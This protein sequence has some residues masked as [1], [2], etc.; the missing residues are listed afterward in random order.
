MLTD[1]ALMLAIFIVMILMIIFVPVLG[2][3]IQLFLILPFLLYSSKH[4]V[5]YSI[6]L[7]IC[8]M[9]L[10]FIL[11]SFAGLFF[12]FL[13]GT[14]GLM[15]GYCIK[16]KESKQTIYIAS[17]IVFLISLVIVFVISALFF[18]LNFLTE[19]QQIF[20]TA[21]D[22]YI[23]TL[24]RLGQSPPLELQ[25]QLREM[26]R[27]LGLMAPTL[28]AGSA[29]LNVIVIIAVNFPI[30]K[31]LGVDVPKFSPFRNLSFP[32]SIVWI[33]LVVILLS[34]IVNN[35]S[36]PFWQMVILNASFILQ[37]LLVIQGLSFIFYFAHLKKWPRAIP[38]IAVVLTPFLPFFLSIVRVLGI[39]DIGFNL[40]QRL[41]QS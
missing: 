1:G 29:F 17:S 4:S 31:R 34:F 24:Q 26:I 8:A 36:G 28:M 14:T 33:Y 6:I 23:E 27:I 38:I 16:R 37:S 11:G 22:Q 21:I 18:N 7:G 39:I 5:K 15:M 25:E 13:Y 2:V 9:L 35:D 3:I 41:S 32:K 30:A 19:Y 40:R 20:Q 12:A 10:S